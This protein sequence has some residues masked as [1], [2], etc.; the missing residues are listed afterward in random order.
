MPNDP[1]IHAFDP[2]DASESV[3][4]ERNE[5]MLLHINELRGRTDNRTS[6]LMLAKFLAFP[7]LARRSMCLAGYSVS[8]GPGAREIT[9]PLDHLSFV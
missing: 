3:N 1:A 2:E 7:S 5:A 4:T 8:I 6:R 9:G